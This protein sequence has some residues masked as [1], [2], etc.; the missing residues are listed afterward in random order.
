MRIKQLLSKRFFQKDTAYQ[1][2]YEWEDIFCKELG[3]SL[4]LDT[5]IGTLAVKLGNF[6]NKLP[7]GP[8]KDSFVFE[9][10]PVYRRTLHN[11]RPNVIPLLIDFYLYTQEELARFYEMYS[12][13]KLVLV[14]SKEIYDY[15]KSVNCPLNIGHLALSITDN[16]AITSNTRFEKDIDFA[17][18]G[19]QNPILE[20]WLETFQKKHG[21]LKVAKRKIENGHFNYYADND[22]VGCADTREDCINLL[23]RSRVVLYSTK[24]LDNDYQL[25]DTHG[26][27]QVTPRFLEYIVTG[28][29]ILARY[30]DNSDTRY[31]EMERICK[32]LTT[33]EMFEQELQRCLA[34]SVD[35]NLYS[36]YVSK[37]YTTCRV[38]E[39][40]EMVKEL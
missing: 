34:T 38:K 19:R 25:R 32:N 31:Y 33:Y 18:I 1:L 4:R 15:L 30:A 12:K 22:F 9:M 14:S 36:D 21:K 2:V 35:M 16:L 27:S 29:H 10:N 11:N 13:N 23:K 20:E 37:H 8:R 24:G 6:Y 40:I 5:E 26:F 3:A 39:L 28:N 7:L 17:L